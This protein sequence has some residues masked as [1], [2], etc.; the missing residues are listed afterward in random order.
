MCVLQVLMQSED[1]VVVIVIAV[2][3]CLVL[4]ALLRCRRYS[5]VS[6]PGS[7]RRHQLLIM[8]IIF[9]ILWFMWSFIRLST[10]TNDSSEKWLLQAIRN[11]QINRVLR[12]HLCYN[13]YSCLKVRLQ[14]G[15]FHVAV[16][17]IVVTALT[18]CRCDGLCMFFLCVRNTTDILKFG[19]HLVT[20][21]FT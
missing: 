1:L 7:H 10:A 21:L 9:V 11:E 8:F 12:W 6:L 2:A 18:C 13:T 20:F 19:R 15:Y 4:F 14:L 5:K 16:V 17:C 3:G